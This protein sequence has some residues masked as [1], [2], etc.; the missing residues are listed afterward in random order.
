MSAAL[1]TQRLVSD[2]IALRCSH[3]VAEISTLFISLLFFSH[4]AKQIALVNTCWDITRVPHCRFGAHVM[5]MLSLCSHNWANFV[6]VLQC[7]ACWHCCCRRKPLLLGA[8]GPWQT[9][10]VTNRDCLHQILEICCPS[11][12]VGWG[13]LYSMLRAIFTNFPVHNEHCHPQNAGINIK[14]AVPRLPCTGN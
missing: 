5:L 1:A 13:L 9:G 6:F 11:M 7:S 4:A 10:V 2:Q 14:L 3:W 8:Y 12:Q